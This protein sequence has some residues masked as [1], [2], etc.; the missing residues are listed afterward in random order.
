[1][2]ARHWSATLGGGRNRRGEQV[3]EAPL[4]L[5]VGMGRDPITGKLLGRACPEYPSLAE[6]IEARARA[7][8]P[9]LGP[10]SRAEAVAAIETEEAERGT[11]R[12][13]VGFDFTFSIPKSASVLWAAADAGTQLR[14]WSALL[15]KPGE[16]T[17]AGSSSLART[18]T[19]SSLVRDG[20]NG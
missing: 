15:G 10:V 6:R 4:Q 8:D 16:H 14:T 12:A 11:R 20:R 18:E 5:L 13:V 7:L 2:L 9:A 19:R 1:V 17:G 3:S